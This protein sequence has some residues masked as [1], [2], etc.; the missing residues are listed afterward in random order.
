LECGAHRFAVEQEYKQLMANEKAKRLVTFTAGSA[1]TTIENP[2][3]AEWCASCADDNDTIL[4]AT[5]TRQQ[6][7]LLLLCP[8]TS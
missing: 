7:I 5:T 6:S 3:D 1:T 8:V 4:P 2:E